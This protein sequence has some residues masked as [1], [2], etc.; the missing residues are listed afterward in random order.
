MAGLLQIAEKRNADIFQSKNRK[1]PK[2]WPNNFFFKYNFVGQLI[3]PQCP[4]NIKQNK[5]KRRISQLL[6]ESCC[7]KLS[8]VGHQH[9]LQFWYEIDSVN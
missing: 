3:R 2:L 8:P 4:F 6:D 5:Q 1:I 9:K 7:R